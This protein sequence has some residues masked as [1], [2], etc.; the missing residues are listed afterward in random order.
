MELLPALFFIL[1]LIIGSFLNV[2]IL[3]HGSK[4][5]GGR[6]ACFT[7]S[8]TLAWYE[9]IPVL[10][11]FFQ[12]GRC[13]TCKSKISLQYPLVEV[14]TAVVF[15]LLGLKF[16]YLIP[17]SL[18]HFAFIFSLYAIV[19]SLLIIIAA[20]DTRHTIIPDVFVYTVTFIVFFLLFAQGVGLTLWS[21]P[22]ASDLLAGPILSLPFVILH[23]ASRGKWMGLGDAKLVLALGFLLGLSRGA[24]AVLLAFFIGAVMGVIILLLK[25]SR[26]KMNTEIP[27]GPFLIFGAFVA[28]FCGVSLIN[29][30]H[31]FTL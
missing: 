13:R 29:F 8:K 1:G 26:F 21:A 23:I 11:Y 15:L 28:F 16:M 6:S 4:T 2:V 5:L 3:R 27:F 22:S 7:C 17:V 10:S 25:K 24:S 14:I 18:M 20:Y 12:G 30:M 31:F 9:M 19:W